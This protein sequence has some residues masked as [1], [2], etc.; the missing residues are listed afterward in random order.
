M[1]NKLALVIAIVLGLI[2]AYGFLHTWSSR[3][4]QFKQEN[5]TVNVA[6]A[7]ER[8]K[9]GEEVR[10][11]MLSMINIPASAVTPDHIVE[12]EA[13]RLL[14]QTIVRSVER[15]EPL[16]N[17]YF[18][19]P[20]EKLRDRLVQGERAV[21]LRVDAIS[22][23]GGNIV[24]GSR[25]D[26]IGTFPKN[27]ASAQAV[28]N[29]GGTEAD[30]T[31]AVL[32]NVSVLAVDSQTRELEYTTMAGPRAQSYGTVTL[33]LSPDE[34][35]LLVFA[36]QYGTL[37]F[38]LRPDADTTSSDVQTSVTDSDFVQKAKAAQEKRRERMEKRQPM[39]LAH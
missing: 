7:A 9:A 12:G 39:E 16:L 1:R 34:A 21:T 26:I 31:M 25:V 28:R 8:I 17:S 22:G 10:P 5:K 35:V 36:Q 38:A 27:G 29:A 33:A 6:A 23:V 20:M 18:R 3:E 2:A 11:G 24:P 32:S 37:T 30:Q 19:R 4:Q 15:G 13:T 14:G